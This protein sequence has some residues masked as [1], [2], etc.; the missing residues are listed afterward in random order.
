MSRTVANVGVA[1]Y[2]AEIILVFGLVVSAF[3]GAI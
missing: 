2:T 3:M 1:F